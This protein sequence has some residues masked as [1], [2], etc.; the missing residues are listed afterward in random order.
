MNKPIRQSNMDHDVKKHGDQYLHNK[1][2]A[3]RSCI[4][5]TRNPESKEGYQKQ[6]EY[7]LSIEKSRKQII[8]NFDRITT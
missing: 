2:H 6:L 8:M 5:T 4:K 7:A 1:I 3:I